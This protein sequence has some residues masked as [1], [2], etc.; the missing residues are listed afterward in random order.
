MAVTCAAGILGHITVAAVIYRTPLYRHQQGYM[1]L[2]GQM[3]TDWLF[4]GYFFGRSICIL[5]ARRTPLFDNGTLGCTID[6]ILI[7]S[8][9]CASLYI[10]ALIAHGRYRAIVTPFA[11]L[12]NQTAL[13]LYI[14][15]W[16]YSW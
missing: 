13:R 11:P 6:G 9:C 10:S 8:F 3:V 15:A 16:V 1:L 7:A 12:S 2:L 14:A 4:C 5:V